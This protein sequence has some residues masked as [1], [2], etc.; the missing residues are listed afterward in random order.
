VLND[1]PTNI[2][3]QSPSPNSL[4]IT[5]NVILANDVSAYIVFYRESLLSTSPYNTFG[6]NYTI[7]NL[8]WLKPGTEYMFRVLA[9]SNGRG[10]GVASTLHYIR[11]ME[12]SKTK[13]FLAF[14]FLVLN[15]SVLIVTFNL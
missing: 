10:N 15:C 9:Y 4:I 13:R 8:T 7:A 11:T 6:T 14:F 3:A 2:S 12:K 1:A 5:W